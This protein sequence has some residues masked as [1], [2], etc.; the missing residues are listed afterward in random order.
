ML[1]PKTLRGMNR[2]EL[3]TLLAGAGIGASLPACIFPSPKTVPVNQPLSIQSRSARRPNILLI[4]TDQEHHNLKMPTG[5][6]LP[7]HDWLKSRGVTFNHYHVVTAPCTPSRATIFTGQH[8]PL[9]RMFDNINFPYVGNLSEKLQ[10][11]GTMLRRAGYYTAYKGKWHLTR[12]AGSEVKGEAPKPLINAL[13]PFGFSD[14]NPTG[15]FHGN[16]W[17]G[18]KHDPEIAEGAIGWLKNRSKAIAE[19]KPWFLMVGFVNPHDIMFAD[20]NQK[21][22]KVQ[23]NVGPFEIQAPPTS[24]QYTKDWKPEL[25]RS[26]TDSLDTKPKAQRD[27]QRLTDIF[28]G[29]M[30]L[31]RKDMYQANANYY[32]NCIQDVDSHIHEVLKALEE[33]G[34]LDNTIIVFTADHGEM[35]GAHGLRQKGPLMYS[36][37]LNVPMVVVHPDNKRNAGSTT[38]GLACSLDIAPTLLSMAGLTR[39]MRLTEFPLLKGYDMSSVLMSPG[40]Q[41]ERAQ[42]A[43]GVLMTYDSLNSVDVDFMKSLTRVVED[44]LKGLELTMPP[45][46]R[47]NFDKRGFMRAVYDGRYKFARY[48]APVRYNRPTT[49]EELLKENDLELYDTQTDPD[50]MNNLAHDPNANKEL[51]VQMNYKLE[52]LISTEIGNDT[53][54]DL[55]ELPKLRP[56]RFQT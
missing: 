9:T 2:R 48:F 3:L 6:T 45:A 17:T 36:E 21:G 29:E 18:F 56:M 11:V 47:P 5:Y 42:K 25:A 27:W 10:T 31:D 44:G 30:P 14:F 32:L 12:S 46:L 26:F 54:I 28:F 15:D 7:G 23:V 40:S 19:E 37:N 16:H 22:E 33:T 43:S 49:F 55:P 20:N 52:G 51:V 38:N 39:D 24:P 50:E 1:D 34:Q 41:S 53:T 13:E 35:L 8:V 4:V